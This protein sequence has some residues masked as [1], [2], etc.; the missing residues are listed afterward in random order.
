MVSD[1]ELAQVAPGRSRELAVSGFVDLDELDP[2]WFNKAYYLAPAAEE[3][4]KTYALLRDAM[5]R[6]NRVGI[7][8]FVM[9]G[10]QHLAAIRASGNGLTLS[11]LFFADEVRDP[12]KLLDNLPGRTSFGK[13][14]LAMATELIESM[15]EDWK[16]TRYHDTYTER[17]KE[18]IEAKRKG[19]E[20]QVAEQAPA[21]TE[22]VDL[23]EALRRSVDSARARRKPAAKKTAKNPSAAKKSARKAS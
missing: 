7:A 10:K 18:L 9:H 19:R 20:I 3:N 15:A 5:A 8:T 12:K 16:P 1:E 17:V 6:T 14:E 11:T 13:G 22:V 4:R 23:L 2:I 21:G